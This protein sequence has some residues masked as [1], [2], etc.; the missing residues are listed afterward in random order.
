MNFTGIWAAVRSQAMAMAIKNIAGLLIVLSG[1]VVAEEISEP[2]N[3]EKGVDLY[4]FSKEGWRHTFRWSYER[5]DDFVPIYDVIYRNAPRLTASAPAEPT[6]NP[7]VITELYVVGPNRPKKLLLADHKLGD[8]NSWVTLS[9][10]D[11]VMLTTKLNEERLFTGEGGYIGAGPSAEGIVERG[12][13]VSHESGDEDS[14]LD[15]SK[16]REAQ[17][18]LG[19]QVASEKSPTTNL[20]EQKNTT[21]TI[22]AA[23]AQPP[24]HTAPAATSVEPNNSTTN[25]AREAGAAAGVQNP[26]APSGVQ[27]ADEP[28]QGIDQNEGSSATA[29]EDTNVDTLTVASAFLGLVALVLVSLKRMRARNP[30]TR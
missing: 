8:G 23:I 20:A 12:Q 30:K 13:Q 25:T 6:E 3:Y 24:P 10:S 15:Y 9:D 7:E 18:K 19:A 21:D 28:A 2:T 14:I 1:G 16:Y 27:L 22:H 11:F 5:H 17:Q 26:V 4:A 29:L